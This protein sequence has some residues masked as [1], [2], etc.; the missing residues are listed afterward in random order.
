MLIEIHTFSFKKIHLKMSSGKWR[1]F[2]LDLSVLTHRPQSNMLGTGL[3]VTIYGVRLMCLRVICI[4]LLNSL[5]PIQYAGNR[6]WG[7]YV[8]C[9]ADMSTCNLY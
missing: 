8:R 2:C 7:D 9:Q 5:V 3:G 1:P 4:D 6:T